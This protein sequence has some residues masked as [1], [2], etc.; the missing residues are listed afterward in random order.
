MG[1]WRSVAPETNNRDLRIR[2]PFAS[3]E[4]DKRG[5]PIARYEISKAMWPYPPNCQL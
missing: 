2:K 3:Q 1:R 4:H 5:G